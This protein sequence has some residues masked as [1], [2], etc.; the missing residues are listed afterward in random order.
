[1]RIAPRQATQSEDI[2]VRCRTVTVILVSIVLQLN[3]AYR[4]EIDST[5]LLIDAFVDRVLLL[6]PPALMF[7]NTDTDQSVPMGCVRL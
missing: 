5:G 7:P 6:V 2:I 3:C 1:M 4:D